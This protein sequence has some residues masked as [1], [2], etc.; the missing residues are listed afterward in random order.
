MSEVGFECPWSYGTKIKEVQN[1]CNKNKIRENMIG[2]GWMVMR[3]WGGVRADG[4]GAWCQ[5]R[6]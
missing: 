5:G 6:W 2:R 3:S 4:D 1:A